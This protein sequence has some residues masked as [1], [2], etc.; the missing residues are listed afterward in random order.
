ML[1]VAAAGLSGIGIGLL[2]ALP[3]IGPVTLTVL[4]SS[5][6]YGRRAGLSVAAGA[7]TVD[8]VLCLLTLVTTGLLGAVLGFLGAHPTLS[9]LVQFSCVAL[10]IGFGVLQLRQRHLTGSAPPSTTA[11]PP[12]VLQHLQQRGHYFLGLGLTVMNMANP[13]FL[14]SLAY[15]GV[16]A[17]EFG[18]VQQGNPWSILAFALGFGLGNLGWLSLLAYGTHHVRYRLSGEAMERL[19]RIVGVALIGV[20]AMLGIRILLTTRWHELVR[21]LPAF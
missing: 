18:L 19:Y 7:A 16:I 2:F 5:L 20:G 12:P 13:T 9:L 14:P 15:V 10:L 1:A 4:R 8:F 21:F 6:L 17:H 3:A 11:E